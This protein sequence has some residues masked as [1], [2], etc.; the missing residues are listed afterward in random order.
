[1]IRFA[2]HPRSSINRLEEIKRL[3]V[4]LN[5]SRPS[6]NEAFNSEAATEMAGS[7]VS[8]VLTDLASSVQGIYESLE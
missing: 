4:Y 1:M 2:R 5:N 3:L 6:V 8:A 7:D